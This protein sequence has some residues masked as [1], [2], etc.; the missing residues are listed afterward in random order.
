MGRE[1]FGAALELLS[2]PLRKARLDDKT[3]TL[4]LNDTTLIE[5]IP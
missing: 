4:C 5:G 2:R 1:G 3:R